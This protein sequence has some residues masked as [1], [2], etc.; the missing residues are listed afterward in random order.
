M[1]YQLCTY[2]FY[3]TFDTPSW[4]FWLAL[5][6]LEWSHMTAMTSRTCILIAGMHRSGTSALSRV[7]GLLGGAHP[8]NLMSAAPTNKTGHWESEP[9]SIFHDELLTSAGSSWDDWATCLPSWRESPTMSDYRPRALALFESE[10]GD[11][12]LTV[13]KDPRLCRLLPFWLPLFEQQNINTYT[14]IPIRNPKEVAAS[15]AKRNGLDIHYNHLLWLRYVLEAEAGSRGTKRAFVTYDDLLE[16]SSFVIKTTED[17][18]GIKWPRT[19]ASTTAEI[20]AYL[21]DQHRHEKLAKNSVSRDLFAIDWLRTTYEVMLRWSDGGEDTSDYPVL[22]TILKDFNLAAQRFGQVIYS[23]K[24]ARSE[25]VEALKLVADRDGQI[26][27][28]FEQTARSSHEHEVASA[29]A[30]SEI[31]ALEQSIVTLKSDLSNAR[32]QVDLEQ[33]KSAAALTTLQA[34]LVHKHANV[35]HALAEQHRIELSK[36][37]GD[38]KA[39][40]DALEQKNLDQ[41]FELNQISSALAQKKA[42]T[43]DYQIDIEHLEDTKAEL[44]KSTSYFRSQLMASTTRGSKLTSQIQSIVAS[45][46]QL[47]DL[48][49]LPKRFHNARVQ[50]ILS[51]A[52][53]V[54]HDWYLQKYPDV[55]ALGV[56][57]TLHYVTYGASEG[58][59][60]NPDHDALKPQ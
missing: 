18:L 12:S 1:I 28:L 30:A 38:A 4:V 43:E 2:S 44:I 17:R 20:D 54:D 24:V 48:P 42:E 10:Y 51:A 23:G 29:V 16:N 56:D 7:I 22:D 60:P 26:T 31:L 37:L 58:R 57:P 25:Q 36:C 40:F 45:M 11:A 49:F 14:I 5:R 46:D 52:N 13:F 33:A 19:S 41:G 59:S 47:S 9:L 15:I 32:Q 6:T 21:S 27:S 35:M 53:I 8:K 3:S 34:E 50:S 39:A 55:S